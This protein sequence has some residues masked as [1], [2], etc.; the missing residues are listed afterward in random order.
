MGKR[1]RKGERSFY[2][3]VTNIQKSNFSVSQCTST[4]N[5]IAKLEREIVEEEESGKKLEKGF[6]DRSRIS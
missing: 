1:K 5:I 3:P 6:G 2:L 4:N